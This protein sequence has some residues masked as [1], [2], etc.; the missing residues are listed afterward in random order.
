LVLNERA[1]LARDIHDTL[2]QNL[3]GTA[4]VLEAVSKRLPDSARWAEEQVK[5]VKHQI[6]ESIR[7]ARRSIWDLRSETLD[8]DDIVAALRA[9]TGRLAA[10]GVAFHFHAS[11]VPTRSE[12]SREEQLLRI[13]QEAISNA[14]R[15]AAS[16]TIRVE[17]AYDE[18]S[19]RIRVV[20]NGKGFDYQSTV[21]RGGPHLGLTTMKER[22]NQLGDQERSW[23]RDRG[24]DQRPVEM[25][26]QTADPCS[27]CGRSC[28][29][30]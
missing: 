6:E 19:V 9:F 20:D 27:V 5:S 29:D 8:S 22:A 2:L 10:T 24:R 26:E 17:V 28:V 23:S 7:D 14:V 16:T 13:G 30:A 1:R 4:L 11:G 12:R 15:H 3:A 18:S 25:N 21:C